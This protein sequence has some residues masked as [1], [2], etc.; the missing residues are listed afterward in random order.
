MAENAYPR[1]VGERETRDW[2]PSCPV[3]IKKIRL[4]RNEPE[5]GIEMTVETDLP[6]MQLYSG[7][8]LT[9]RKGKGGSEIH[10]R[11]AACFE[12]Q[13]YPNA[14]NCY[15]FPSPVLR[16]DEEYRRTI[17]FDFKC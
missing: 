14:M 9:D 10:W 11:D 1:V 12:T 7:N 6:G 3:Q 15:A 16:P 4:V 17:I 2:I 8:F 5:G 13:L